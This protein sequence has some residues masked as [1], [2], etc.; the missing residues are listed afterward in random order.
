[1]AVS[2]NSL[3]SAGAPAPAAIASS[4]DFWSSAWSAATALST[5]GLVTSGVSV[6]IP[7]EVGFGLLTRRRSGFWPWGTTRIVLAG[8]LPPSPVLTALMATESDLGWNGMM[9]AGC[10]TTVACVRKRTP[11]SV[12][13]M[14]PRGIDTPLLVS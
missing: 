5:S 11:P 2:G 1:M 9:P 4:N 3:V 13:T 12:E 6:W 10:R 8:T 14:L 7:P